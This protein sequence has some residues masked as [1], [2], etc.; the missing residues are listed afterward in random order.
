MVL[1]EQRFRDGRVGRGVGF[2][3]DDPLPVPP[4]CAWLCEQ[5]GLDGAQAHQ[6][7]NMGLGFVVI[8]AAPDAPGAAALLAEH[9]PGT[10]A[11]GRVSAEPGAVVLPSLGLRL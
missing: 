11:I 6:V 2:E 10:R 8:V 7:F 5:G 4:I 3:I 1:S 9:H